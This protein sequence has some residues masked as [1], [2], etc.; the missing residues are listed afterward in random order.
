MSELPLH[1]LTDAGFTTDE[2]NSIVDH[3][4]KGVD[5][6]DGRGETDR[7]DVE[8]LPEEKKAAIDKFNLAVAADF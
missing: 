3:L 2:A 6:H 4:L 8:A 7:I 1:I 5:T